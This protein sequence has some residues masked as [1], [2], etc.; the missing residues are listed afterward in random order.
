MLLY[1]QFYN[2][3]V[4][5]REPIA[6]SGFL[7]ALLSAGAARRV[8]TG[9]RTALPRARVPVRRA[10]PAPHGPL[11][12]R[13]RLRLPSSQVLSCSLL[14]RVIPLADAP[15][16]PDST[17]TPPPRCT[18]RAPLSSVLRAINV[19]ECLRLRHEW[20]ARYLHD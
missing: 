18:Y 10:V 2:R 13:A 4:H 7:C 19:P 9:A 15:I 1:I 6:F 8:A 11:A 5:V 3:L 17:R 12:P 16:R 20:R 14:I